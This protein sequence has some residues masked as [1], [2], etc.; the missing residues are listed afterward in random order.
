M[1]RMVSY[2]ILAAVLINF[3]LTSLFTMVS[4][5]NY[6]GG[7]ALQRLHTLE[8]SRRNV[9]VHMDVAACQTGVSRFL[10][11]NKDWKYEKSEDLSPQELLLHGYTHLLIS[12]DS[13][14]SKQM[15]TIKDNFEVIDESKGANVLQDYWPFRFPRFSSSTTRIFT[16]RRTNLQ[17]L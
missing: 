11:L 5:V 2:G 16:L 13:F 17:P 12:A 9:T 4:S 15:Q 14:S 6:P 3:L 10:E 7:V 1:G 8:S